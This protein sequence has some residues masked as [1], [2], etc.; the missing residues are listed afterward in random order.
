MNDEAG[1]IALMP[2]EAINLRRKLALVMLI[3]PRVS[4]TTV[5]DHRRR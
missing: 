4:Q 3:E 2:H 5:M 1:A